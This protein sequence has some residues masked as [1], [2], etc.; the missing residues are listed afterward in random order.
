MA[1]SFFTQYDGQRSGQALPVPELREDLLPDAEESEAAA[2]AKIDLGLE[3]PAE[4]W[5]PL[6]PDVPPGFCARDHA[7]RPRRFVDGK[8]V[9]MVV[10]ALR[11]PQG[12]PVP[13]RLSQLGAVVLCEEDGVL[14][15]RAEIVERAVTFITHFFPWHEIEALAAALS[16]RGLRLVQ[17]RRPAVDTPDALHDY[18]LLRQVTQSASNNEMKQLEEGLAAQFYDDVPVVIDGRLEPR[19][20]ERSQKTAV[21]GVIKTHQ[22]RYLHALGMQVLYSLRP[23]QRTPLFLL[24]TASFPVVSFYL[25][26]APGLPSEGFVRVELPRGYY[27]S[28]PPAERPGYLGRLAETLYQYRCRQEDYGRAAVSLHPIVRAEESLGALLGP[29]GRLTQQFYRLTG[30]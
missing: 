2:G 23:R 12:Y 27:E 30:L 20:G 25:R 9:G 13:V 5:T 18:E 6:G 4:A 8:D 1:I 11:A 17:A 29:M 28:I 19:F 21:V 26:L 14:R 3:R 7:L 10:V 15:R 24:E 22:R 16:E